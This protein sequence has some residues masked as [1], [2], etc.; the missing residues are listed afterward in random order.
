MRN[1]F[2][3]LAVRNYR[4]F[5]TG[6][7]VKLIGVWMQFTAQDWLVL[8][9]S[10]D[11]ATALGWV[12]ALQFA[13]VLLLTLYGGKLADRFDKRRLLIA[14]NAA[15]GASALVLGV[16][17]AGGW[18]QLWHVFVFAAVLGVITAIETP[19]RQSFVSELVGRELLPNALALSAAT[20]NSARIIGPAVSGVAI[21]WLGLGPVFLANAVLCLGPLV[22]AIRMRPAEL[23]RAEPTRIP[24]RDARIVDGLRYVWRRPDLVAP[25]ALML[26]VGAFGFN[27]QVTIP[28][29]AKTAFHADARSFGL[30]STSLALGALGGALAGT[31]RR[32]RPSFYL[33]LTAALLFAVAETLVGFAPGYLSAAVLL[34]PTGFFMIYFAQASNQRVQLGT[35]AEYRGR[36]M[37]L[38]ILVFFGTTPVGALLVG[39]L[40]EIF[41]PR[42]G[43][44]TGGLVS[45][46]AV[47]VAGSLQLRRAGTRIWVHLR[48][49][50]HVHLTEP[51]RDGMPAVELRVPAVRAAVR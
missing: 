27:F 15:F 10:H 4:L 44:W 1:V 18:V 33:V 39:W 6:Q 21:A 48:P 30:L 2:R 24:S 5:A 16:L 42:S 35:D 49:L 14:A 43:F 37:A 11:S 41:G 9:L 47:V 29:L 25:M 22:S 3:S 19:V 51:A 34:V 36:V 32:G 26:L 8:Q 13:P 20:F 7:L 40:A 46:V 28:V 31:G 45:L 17:V 38:Y 50:P 23:H 12:T